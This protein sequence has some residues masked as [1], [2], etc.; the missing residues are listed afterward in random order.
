M[1]ETSALTSEMVREAMGRLINAQP[2]YCGSP[3]RPHVVHPKAVGLTNCANCFR[4]VDAGESA[5]P[6][7][8]E[9]GRYPQSDG[10]SQ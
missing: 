6:D 7:T 8:A 9:K 4:V 2:V 3:E 1:T 5:A 10:G